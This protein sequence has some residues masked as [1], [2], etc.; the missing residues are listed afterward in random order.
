MKLDWFSPLPPAQT[1]VAQYTARLLP[2]L[3]RQAALTLW[4]DQTDWDAQVEEFATVRRYD[5]E[6]MPWG[7][8]NRADMSIYHI[9][10]SQFH[11]AIWRVSR[12][13]PGV[14]VLHDARLQDFFRGVYQEHGQRVEYLKV[15]EQLYGVR[16]R[17][18]ASDF[19][20]DTLPS[21]Y[22]AERYPFTP[23]AIA[24]ALGVAVHTRESYLAAKRWSECPL[25][26][27]ALPYPVVAAVPRRPSPPPYRLILFG[28]ISW[29]RRLNEVLKA[30]ALFPERGRLRLDVYGWLFNTEDAR[31]RVRALGLDGLVTLHGF[32]PTT[33]LD[34]ALARAHLA[35]NLR[36]PTM[37]EASFSQLQI[38]AYGLPSLVTA[39][40]WYA[41]LPGEA[42]AFVRPEHEQAD[43]HA[44]WRALLADPG[45][46][47]RMGEAGRR[48][49]EAHHTPAAYAH[50][51]I[52]LA[53]EARRC[54]ADAA[55]RQLA[56]R[57]A[58]EMSLWLAP[59][60]PPDVFRH[61][62]TSIAM[63][64]NKGTDV[65]A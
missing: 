26:H 27:A 57:A 60:A 58:T 59:A 1:A 35:I 54:R 18:A 61:A 21:A 6:R 22:M 32:V 43:L 11:R 48:H 14:V 52:D 46:F 63:L 24:G 15:A 16:G 41:T 33:H 20:R 31:A 64:A 37:G 19:W 51:I 4:T 50:A 47:A 8:L 34:A 38:W 56:D 25:V 40:G 23:L 29:N 13:A 39:A 53:T 42:V 17:N 62:A 28:Y 45:C 10:N 9:G 36:S 7:E 30:L 2:A 49:L 5:P 3:C 44:H 55:A 12:D 65:D